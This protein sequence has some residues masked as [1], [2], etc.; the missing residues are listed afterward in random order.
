[1]CGLALENWDLLNTIVKLN[2]LNWADEMMDSVDDRHESVAK[3][4]ADQDDEVIALW[5]IK[6][7]Q[8]NYKNN[9]EE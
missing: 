5:C 6:Y 9:I 7:Q 2:P 3:W 4:I 8:I 1:M